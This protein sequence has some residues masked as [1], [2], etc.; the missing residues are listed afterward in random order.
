VSPK[1]KQAFADLR[2]LFVSACSGYKFYLYK[3]TRRREKRAFSYMLE[4]FLYAAK[5]H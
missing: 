1:E 5:R 2:R 3:K 4:R